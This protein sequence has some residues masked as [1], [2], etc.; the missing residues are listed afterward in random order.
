MYFCI[1]HC[2]GYWYTNGNNLHF[3]NNCSNSL[4]YHFFLFLNN[5]IIV[6]KIT[7][8]TYLILSKIVPVWTL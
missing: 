1:I 2:N 7:I 5:R 4:I 8:L 6:R 3:S